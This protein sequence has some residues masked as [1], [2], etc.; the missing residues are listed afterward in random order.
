M[1]IAKMEER[2]GRLKEAV[3]AYREQMQV[4]PGSTLADEASAAL[5][6]LEKTNP[7]LFPKPEA[8]VAPSAIGPATSDAAAAGGSGANPGALDVQLKAPDTAA[9]ESVSGADTSLKLKIPDLGSEA[10]APSP[11]E[12]APAETPAKQ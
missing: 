12:T 6:R 10:A 4:F 8:P 9:P 7:D 11:A 3:A 1:N 2:R 5:N